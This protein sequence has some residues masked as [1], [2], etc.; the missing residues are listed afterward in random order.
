[1]LTHFD[2]VVASVHGNFNQDMKMATARVCKAISHPATRI[3]GH[4]TGRLLLARE[5]VPLDF[6]QVID[7]AVKHDVAIEINANPHRLDMDWRHSFY[8]HKKGLKI[9]I[10]PD[11]HSVTGIDDLKYG[12]NVA[13]KGWWTTADVINTWPLE[14]VERWLR[15]E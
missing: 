11:A 2:F 1:V 6:E 9:V 12:I 3:L 5:G 10:S 4:A 7:C 15:R 14:K 13:R 8:A